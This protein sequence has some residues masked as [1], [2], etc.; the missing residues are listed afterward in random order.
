VF[1]DAVVTATS[2]EAV[3]WLGEHRL[4]TVTAR[5]DAET[6]YTAADFQG[7]VAIVLGS[8]AGGLSAAWRGAETQAVRL[9]M[10]GLADSLNVSTAAAVLFYE[11]LRQRGGSAAPRTG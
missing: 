5:P 9:P 1:R 2:A 8:E 11:A 4:K 7:G 6:L 3:A 10:C